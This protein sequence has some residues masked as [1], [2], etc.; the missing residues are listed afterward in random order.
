MIDYTARREA[1]R[2]AF[3]RL[4]RG[5]RSAAAFDLR[6]FPAVVSNILT[7]RID[8]EDGLTRLEQWLVSEDCTKFRAKKGLSPTVA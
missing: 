4:G 6:M 1:A 8:S 2:R 7:G 3:D 5:S